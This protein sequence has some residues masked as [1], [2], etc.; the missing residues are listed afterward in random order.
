[1]LTAKSECI[2]PWDRCQ[3]GFAQAILN[4]SGTQIDRLQSQKTVAQCHSQ[5]GCAYV[6]AGECFC[7]PDVL[8]V[9]GGG[10]PPNCLPSTETQFSPPIGEY[11]VVDARVASDVASTLDGKDLSDIIGTSFVFARDGISTAD[12]EC[13]E[14]AIRETDSPENMDDPLLADVM[15][16][17]IDGDQ[18]DGDKRLLRSWGYACEG[19]EFIDLLQ[20]DDRV[21]VVPWVNSSLTLILERQLTRAQ[22]EHIQAVLKD[23]K[24]LDQT[25]SRILD[26]ATL[27]AISFWAEYRNEAKATYRFKRT[28]ITKNLFDGLGVF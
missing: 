26:E 19:E 23:V 7:P 6:P 27:E 10:E 13:D 25:P 24:F 20:V 14:W 3:I 2:A 8:C 22:V 21:A 4:T 12:L 9:C 18:S 16:G 11:I 17:P 28:A 15:I 1:M 5:T